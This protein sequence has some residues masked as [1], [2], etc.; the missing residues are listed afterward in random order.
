MIILCIIKTS[1]RAHQYQFVLKIVVK[2]T[3][4]EIFLSVWTKNF[5]FS[6][7]YNFKE[8][9][10]NRSCDT[11]IYT[12][13]PDIW[14]QNLPNVIIEVSGHVPRGP[15]DT[16]EDMANY[17]QYL[18]DNFVPAEEGRYSHLHE[19]KCP[20]GLPHVHVILS[21]VPISLENLLM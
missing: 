6:V 8:V 18:K 20:N 16:V 10:S 21:K 2:M 11:V 13:D 14:K 7:S 4:E 1:V 3:E 9:C 17:F 19:T 12:S 5:L 15:K